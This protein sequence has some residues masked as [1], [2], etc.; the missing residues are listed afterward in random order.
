MAKS[1]SLRITD[2][3]RVADE[4]ESIAISI[5][6]S[7]GYLRDQAEKGAEMMRGKIEELLDYAK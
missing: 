6:M 3:L 1:V 7:R 4:M 2:V 5:L